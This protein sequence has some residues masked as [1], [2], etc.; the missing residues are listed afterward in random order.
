M[1]PVHAV[2]DDSGHWYIIPEE[3]SDE[4]DNDIQS[5]S[6]SDNGTFDDKYGKYRTGG[7][8]N[9]IQLYANID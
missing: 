4:F 5:E 1:I 7:S 3:L 6:M 8:L 2:Q 9:S